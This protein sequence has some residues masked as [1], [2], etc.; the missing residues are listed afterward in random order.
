MFDA[1][2]ILKQLPREEQL[3]ALSTQVRIDQTLVASRNNIVNVQDCSDAS[4]Y[5][6]RQVG[7]NETK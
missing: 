1:V 7:Q 6:L 5:N 4:H 3:Y 2:I